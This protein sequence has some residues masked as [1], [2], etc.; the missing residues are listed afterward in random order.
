MHAGELPVAYVQL[1]AG[2]TATETE[3]DTFIRGMIGER[4]AIPK[5]IHIVDTMPLTAVGKIFK[6]ELKRWET[7]DALVSALKDAGVEGAR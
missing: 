7:F 3:L 1:K 2:A 5:R 6:P 4:A